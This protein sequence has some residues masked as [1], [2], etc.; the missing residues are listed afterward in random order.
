M[1]GNGEEGQGHTSEVSIGSRLDECLTVVLGEELHRDGVKVHPPLAGHKG[2]VA[3]HAEL[4]KELDFLLTPTVSSQLRRFPLAMSLCTLGIG[5]SDVLNFVLRLVDNEG[6]IVDLGLST[7]P[8]CRGIGC[9]QLGLLIVVYRITSMV[10]QVC[11]STDRAVGTHA[12]V[13]RNIGPFSITGPGRGHPC[14][15]GGASL[16][17]CARDGRRA[18][19]SEGPVA[20]LLRSA[21]GNV[22]PQGANA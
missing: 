17:N 2:F 3:A 5:H 7:A 13:L 14:A 9:L 8:I 12:P 1:T 15:P 10:G 21:R 19:S 18:G 20:P 6:R 4:A 16:S 11:C 22:A